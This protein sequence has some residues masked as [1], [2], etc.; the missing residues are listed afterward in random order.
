MGHY[1]KRFFGQGGG[2]IITNG[3]KLWLD[4]SNQASYSGS[5]T[6]WNDLSGNGNNGTMVNGVTPLSNAMRF[7]GV[8]DYVTVPYNKTAFGLEFTVQMWID[9]SSDLSGRG[10]WQVANSLS[11]STPWILCQSTTTGLQYYLNGGYRGGVVGS[12]WGFHTLVYSNSVWRVYLN[13][14]L[15]LTIASPIGV[16][17]GNLLYLGNGFNGFFNGQ[18]NEPLIYNRALT[19]EE[20]SYNFNFSRSKYGI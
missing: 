19:P 8:D 4:A 17:G 15:V 5:G 3:L 18:L 20:I 14:T 13:E 10:I 1:A 11:S 2:G 9:L 7:D 16:N 6:T 12:T